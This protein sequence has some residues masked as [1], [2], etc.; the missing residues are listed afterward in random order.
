M[1]GVVTETRGGVVLPT[2]GTDD[3]PVGIVTGVDGVVDVL[4][5]GSI[6]T[7]TQCIQHPRPDIFVPAAVLA[8]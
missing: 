5:T 8:S 4:D 7:P 2:V 6:H 1:A 3:E